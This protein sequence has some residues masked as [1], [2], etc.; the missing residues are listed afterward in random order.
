[1]VISYRFN[2]EYFDYEIS[3]DRYLVAL[4]NIL[5]KEEKTS[6]VDML[7]NCDGC[8]ANLENDYSE[9]LKEYFEKVAYKEY[10]DRRHE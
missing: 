4:Y 10:L 8:V 7:I 5:I 1:M 6:L 9:E 3:H 2:S